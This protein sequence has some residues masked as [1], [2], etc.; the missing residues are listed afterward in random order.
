MKLSLTHKALTAALLCGAVFSL[1]V[2]S[3]RAAEPAEDF[4]KE[5]RANGYYDMALLYLEQAR[6]NPRVDD[7]FK[8]TIVYEQ[9]VTL[10]ESAMTIGNR[11]LR[12]QRLDDAQKKIK[13]FVTENPKHP[14]ALGANGKLADALARR[15]AGLVHEALQ[16]SAAGKKAALLKEA[17]GFYEQ[18]MQM[19]A[20]RR[21]QSN[22]RGI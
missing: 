18:A 15:G 8:A 21:R 13:Q 16:P 3:A 14:K 5:L 6:A 17:R 2:P 9:G 7:A 19:L 22:R 11:D 12:F 4:L 20:S 1:A 10:L